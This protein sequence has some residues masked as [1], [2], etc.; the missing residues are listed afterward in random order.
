MV[1]TFQTNEKLSASKTKTTFTIDYTSWINK[2]TYPTACRSPVNQPYT[3]DHFTS[4]SRHEPSATRRSHV[5]FPSVIIT[6]VTGHIAWL[7]RTDCWKLFTGNSLA[8]RR[9]RGKAQRDIEEN[10]PN[11]AIRLVS[12]LERDRVAG[13]R[14]V[15][16][17]LVIKGNVQMFVLRAWQCNGDEWVQN[18]QWEN[19][20]QGRL[21]NRNF[22]IFIVM[23]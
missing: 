7:S 5:A 10:L 19:K 14:V 1:P 18:K 9:K 15:R 21:I 6:V 2:K 20:N 17:L 4:S 11:N 8:S 23:N 3:W 16:L 22:Y 13:A 12:R